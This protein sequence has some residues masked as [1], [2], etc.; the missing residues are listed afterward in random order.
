MP[1]AATWMELEVIT[2]SESER[3]TLHGATYTQNLNHSRK[4]PVDGAESGPL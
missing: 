4:E 1:C 3:Q 2:L